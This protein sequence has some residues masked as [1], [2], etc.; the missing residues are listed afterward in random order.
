MKKREARKEFN[1]AK[2][3]GLSQKNIQSI[4]RKF[5][6]SIRLHNQLVRKKQVLEKAVLMK[7]ARYRCYTSF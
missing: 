2:K 1:E 5:F 6:Q 7:A 3:F 4:A